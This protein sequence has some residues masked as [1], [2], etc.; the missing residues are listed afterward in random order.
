MTPTTIYTV[1]HSNRL[2]PELLAL[3]RPREIRWLVDVRAHPVSRRLPH[4]NGDALRGPLEAEGITYHWAGGHLGGRRQPL[5]GSPH[6][7]LADPGLRAYAD[8]MGTEPFLRGAAQLVALSRHASTAILCAE[9]HPE[10]C[11]RSLIADYLVVNGHPVVH[12]IDEHETRN[13]SLS[14]FA[15]RESAQLVY[16]RLSTG[17]LDGI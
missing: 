14:P 1:G 7:A 17:R 4:F 11:H 6:V 8:H 12:I 10:H 9:K 15:R 3:L 13:H 2:L 16:D 5:A